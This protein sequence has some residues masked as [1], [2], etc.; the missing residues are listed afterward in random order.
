MLPAVSG[1]T[2]NP[3]VLPLSNT[4]HVTILTTCSSGS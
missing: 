4:L 1:S 2:Y 3:A